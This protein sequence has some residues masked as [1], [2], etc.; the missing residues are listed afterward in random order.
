MILGYVQIRQHAEDYAVQT[1]FAFEMTIYKDERVDSR[2]IQSQLSER[3]KC[4]RT[5]Q[6]I[7][8]I[9][10]NPFEN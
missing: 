1:D 7:I 3:V 8:G 5:G 9:F 2:Y 4:A 6:T 10:K